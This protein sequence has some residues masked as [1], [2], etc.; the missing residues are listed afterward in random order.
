LEKNDKK[1][2]LGFLQKPRNA[3]VINIV[4]F[5][6]YLTL[7][8]IF[9]TKHHGWEQLETSITLYTSCIAIAAI[10][11]IIS[12]YFG[13]NNRGKIAGWYLLFAGILLVLGVLSFEYFYA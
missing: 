8:F 9:Q 11:L 7:C 4:L 10:N 1:I 12:I 2:G 13:L 3:A 5:L 6:I